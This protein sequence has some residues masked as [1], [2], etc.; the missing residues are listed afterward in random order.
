LNS[1][2][3]SHRLPGGIGNCYRVGETELARLR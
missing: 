3:L 1:G 2:H